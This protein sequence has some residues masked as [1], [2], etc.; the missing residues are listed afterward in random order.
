MHEFQ[1]VYGQCKLE[2]GSRGGDLPVPFTDEIRRR[3]LQ[4]EERIKILCRMLPPKGKF[5]QVLWPL[6]E[7]HSQRVVI[8]RCKELFK[9]YPEKTR[10]AM[11]SCFR[12]FKPASI[13]CMKVPVSPRWKGSI[14]LTQKPFEINGDAYHRNLTHHSLSSLGF[15][16][17]SQIA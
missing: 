2:R 3:D 12:T 7:Q 10:I 17:P 5:A 15:A 13:C 6:L 4:G 8:G 14:T 9:S 11:S 16:F 1:P